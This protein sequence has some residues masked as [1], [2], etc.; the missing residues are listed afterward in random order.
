M[1][2]RNYRAD[3][4]LATFNDTQIELSD[5]SFSLGVLDG[6]QGLSIKESL[7]MGEEREAGSVFAEDFTTGDYSAEGTADWKAEAY[8][9]LR[10]K[11][12]ARGRG[13][14][15]TVFNFT[16]TY[17]RKNGKL[18]TV[19]VVGAYF[20]EKSRDGKTGNEGLKVTASM[21]IRG[22]VYENGVDIFGGRL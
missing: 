13:L 8:D 5:G 15:G 11:L 19:K 1:A 2:G 18:T 7:D 3:A 14:F 20:T 16:W 6:L 12:A 21:K 17:K 10:D 22:R 4:S 9:N